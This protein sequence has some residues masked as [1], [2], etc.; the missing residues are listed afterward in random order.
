[1]SGLTWIDSGWIVGLP[2]ISNTF[3][4]FGHSLLLRKELHESI[5]VTSRTLACL[6]KDLVKQR[7]ITTN[8]S[9]QG[10]SQLNGVSFAMMFFS[11]LQLLSDESSYWFDCK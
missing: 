6:E 2:I 1:M 7:Y 4:T 3:M 8:F 9:T 11:I 5:G 10:L